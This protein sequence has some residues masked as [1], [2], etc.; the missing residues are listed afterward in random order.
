VERKAAADH[1]AI[2]APVFISAA[3]DE[4]T[5]Y[6]Q[7]I[8]VFTRRLETDG[9]VKGGLKSHRVP[10]VRHAASQPEA[11]TQGLLFVTEPIAPERGVW[12]DWLTDS[13]KR[14]GFAVNFWTKIGAAGV[15]LTSEQEKAWQAHEVYAARLLAAKLVDLTTTSP[16]ESGYRSSSLVVLAADRATVEALV[17]EDPAVKS[18]LL[19]YEVIQAAE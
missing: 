13:Q 7:Q 6:R 1:R 18:G 14:P 9:L 10:N 15:A 19:N 16:P 8:G 3:E 12:T 11:Y 17:R 4:W 5:Y 2:A